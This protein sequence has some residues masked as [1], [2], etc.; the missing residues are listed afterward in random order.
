MQDGHQCPRGISASSQNWR[1]LRRAGSRRIAGKREPSELP[2]A[3]LGTVGLVKQR[4]I[5][6]GFTVAVAVN[7]A[8]ANIF[9]TADPYSVGK[10]LIA[11][12]DAVDVEIGERDVRRI[13]DLQRQSKTSL[14]SLFFCLQGIDLPVGNVAQ[15]NLVSDMVFARQFI[16]ASARCRVGDVK[17]GLRKSTRRPDIHK[18]SATAVGDPET[19]ILAVPATVNVRIG[20]LVIVVDLLPHSFVFLGSRAWINS[21][22]TTEDAYIINQGILARHP[23]ESAGARVD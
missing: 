2:L 3:N 21:T 4:V 23:L 17:A 15:D 22:V 7:V 18:G 12:D 19:G 10:W 14:A 1:G 13:P 6:R 5:E 20:G 16:N 8:E 9:R 11:A